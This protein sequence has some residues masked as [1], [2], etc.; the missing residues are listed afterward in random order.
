MGETVDHGVAATDGRLFD[1]SQGPRGVY[2][3]LYVSDA[4]RCLRRSGSAHC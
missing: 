3:G 4:G 2:E 1:P